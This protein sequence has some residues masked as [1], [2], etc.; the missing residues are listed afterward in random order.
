MN[1]SFVIPSSIEVEKNF[2]NI[3]MVLYDNGI[4]NI[5]F[6]ENTLITMEDV[7]EV[8][9]WVASLGERKYLNLME[10]A[11]NT[12]IDSLVREFSASDKENKFTIADAI[13]ITSPA[14]KMITD[15]YVNKNKP[16]KPTRV[17]TDREEAVNWL[18]TFK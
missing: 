7:S 10:G 6:K 12:D 5:I 3:K 18:L 1:K 4:M 17:F 14:H 13:V 11:Y 9:L 8:M 2:D 16:V 15:F